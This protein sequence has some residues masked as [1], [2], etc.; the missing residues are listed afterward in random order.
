MGVV[1][2][3]DKFYEVFDKRD[4]DNVCFDCGGIFYTLSYCGRF[5]IA[6]DLETQDAREFCF[7]EHGRELV[8]AM[9]NAK[10]D[11]H[12]DK[13]IREILAGLPPEKLLV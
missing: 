2:A 7:D 3:L 1:T 9:L 10:A 5:I 8:E 12:G 4:T 13:S 6:E 11:P